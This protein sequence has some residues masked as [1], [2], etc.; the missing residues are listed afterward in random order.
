MTFGLSN[1]G[2][3][4]ESNICYVNA[5][6]QLL[7]SVA[8]LRNL[9]KRKGYKPQPDSL[10]PVLD[11]ISRIFNYE[12]PVTSAGPLRQLLGAKEGLSYVMRGEQED[13]ALFSSDQELRKWLC[14]SVRVSVC[15]SLL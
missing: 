13:A 12:G 6:L 5:I 7:H 9:V 15:L 14:P 4:L 8:I 11:E 3:P 1:F 2:S 10:Y